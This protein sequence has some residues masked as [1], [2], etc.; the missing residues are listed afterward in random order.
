MGIPNF[1]NSETGKISVDSSKCNGCGLCV[2]VCSDND[3]IIENG[4]A[5]A[6]GN[7][8]LGC[9]ACGQC[10]AI[11]PKGAISISGRE[12]SVENVFSLTPQDDYA[13]YESLNNL[14][15]RR[16]SIRNFKTKNV[17]S[18]IIEKIINS[19][20]TAPMGIPPWDVNLLVLN[21]QDKVREFSGE[22]SKVCKGMIFMTSPTI[23]SL[24]KPFINR[25]NYKFYKEF[26]SPVLKEYVELYEKG[27]DIITYD[28]PLAIYFYGSPFSDPA[29]SVIAAT[30]AMIAAE[31]LGLGTCMLGAIHPIIQYGS[32]GRKFRAKFGIKHKSQGGLVVI[33]GYS[34]LKYNKGIKRTFASVTH[35]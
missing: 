22:F 4:A 13:Q 28:A 33:F 7:G 18:L 29:D 26:L 17:D 35:Y 16:R 19:A 21:G 24:F 14:L 9:I 25:N 23:L 31:S 11:C 3:L 34:K 8:F 30:Y 5:K 15:Q 10:M 6:S 20:S 32:L 27:T 1:R 12:M 2:Q